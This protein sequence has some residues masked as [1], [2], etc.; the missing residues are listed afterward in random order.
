[1]NLKIQA[2]SS[3][4]RLLLFKRRR[5]GTIS[6]VIKSIIFRT[7]FASRRVVLVSPTRERRR[8]TPTTPERDACMI[9]AASKAAIHTLSRILVGVAQPPTQTKEISSNCDC[10]EGARARKRKTHLV[11]GKMLFGVPGGSDCGLMSMAPSTVLMFRYISLIFYGEPKKREQKRF[12]TMVTLPRSTERLVHFS[13]LHGVKWRDPSSHT[14][15]RQKLYHFNHH[16][17]MIFI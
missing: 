17:K 5:E 13:R 16:R 1:M 14:F 4:V 12:E 10:A 11:D 15:A 9:D 7:C 6:G 2:E 3:V 8:K